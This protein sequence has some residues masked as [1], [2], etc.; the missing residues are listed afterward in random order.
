MNT[1][2]NKFEPE[3]FQKNWLI[4]YAI[5][6]AILLVVEK[7]TEILTPVIVYGK[8]Q[9]SISF[10]T[11]LTFFMLFNCRPFILLD[12][13]FSFTLRIFRL[14]IQQTDWKHKL[15]YCRNHLLYYATNRRSV[16]DMA[17][18]INMTLIYGNVICAWL[19]SSCLQLPCL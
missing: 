5:I 12:S 10:I 7:F 8:I 16:S 19:Y 4:V 2:K 6:E 13:S 11:S 15:L 9:F 3:L 18:L 14:F 17:G 1:S